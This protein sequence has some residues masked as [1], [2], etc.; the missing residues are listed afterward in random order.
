LELRER[1]GG[2]VAAPLV[3]AFLDGYAPSRAVEAALPYY[4][5]TTRRRLAAV[6]AFRDARLPS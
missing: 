3:S 1:Q 5:A 6:Y 2:P 4:Q